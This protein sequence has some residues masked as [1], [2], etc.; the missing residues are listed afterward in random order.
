[1]VVYLKIKQDVKGK[2]IEWEAREKE[3]SRMKRRISENK[4]VKD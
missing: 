4:M 1:M 2:E 3:K